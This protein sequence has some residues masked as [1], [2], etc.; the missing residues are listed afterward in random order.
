MP[1]TSFKVDL[2]RLERIYLLTKE[3]APENCFLNA[4]GQI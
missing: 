2:D 3:T 4:F 1:I